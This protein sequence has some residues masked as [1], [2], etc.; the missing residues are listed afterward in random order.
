MAS[1][2]WVVKRWPVLDS[3]NLEAARQAKNLPVVNQW[4]LAEQQKLGKGRLGRRW[5]S[6]K[7]NLYA[8]ALFVES[9]GIHVAGRL[10][11]VASLAVANTVCSLCPMAE[12][13]IKWP[14]DVLIMKSKISGI[15]VETGRSEN[16]SI[17]VACGIGVNVNLAPESI[18]QPAT[19]IK[20]LAK[21]EFVDVEKVFQKLKDN[22]EEWLRQSKI[23]FADV[24]DKWRSMALGM[25]KPIAIKVGSKRIEGIFDDIEN[26]GALRLVLRDKRT[27]IIRAGDVSVIRD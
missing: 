10:P 19:C 4:I 18:N 9:E 5:E 8:T 25:K 3:T 15:L 24:L 22:F 26:D 13:K 1:D 16:S 21:C 11:F 14:N 20:D 23:C 2:N 7:G 6:P 27:K 12:V 17:W